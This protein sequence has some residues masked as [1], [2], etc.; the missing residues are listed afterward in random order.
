MK[1]LNPSLSVVACKAS[2]AEE[3][4][5]SIS[6]TIEGAEG[7]V[8]GTQHIDIG[9]PT[10]VSRWFALVR[11]SRQFLCPRQGIDKFD[12]S[13]D[14]ILV[15]FLRRDGLHLV[16][17][18]MSLNNV[19][20]VLNSNQDGKVVLAGKNDKLGENTL[21]IL[22]SAGKSFESATQ[23]VMFQARITIADKIEKPPLDITLEAQDWAAHSLEDWYDQ[24]SY[25]T[26]NG[27]GKSLTENALDT[28]LESI[29]NAGIRF[30]TLIIDDGWQS[31]D[32]FGDD[33]RDNRWVMFEAEKRVFPLGL[34]QTISTIK[35]RYPWIKQIG[36]WH[37]IM[38]YWNGISPAGDIHKGYKT[39]VVEFQDSGYFSGGTALVVDSEDVLRFYD[40]F[41]RH[42]CFTA[43]LQNVVADSLDSCHLVALTSSRRILN[44]YSTDCLHPQPAANLSPPIMMRPKYHLRSISSTK[45]YPACPRFPR[46]CF[47]HITSFHPHPQN[48]SFETPMTSFQTPPQATLGTYLLMPIMPYLHGT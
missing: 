34:K 43:Y 17:L 1:D 33:W 7:D 25:C 47:L 42:D 45:P 36:I 12:I 31:V 46:F 41:Y 14:A 44:F 30:S 19:L 35:Q 37:G 18:A 20:T 27:I 40:D 28:A 32:N 16:L 39:R 13:Q 8:S 24:F 9:L 48:N 15:S 2:S 4:I 29:S 6:S 23:A 38:G 3:V 10:N 5:W 26:W 11:E 21:I 22:A